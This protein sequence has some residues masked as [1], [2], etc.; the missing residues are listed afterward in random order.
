[1][2]PTKKPVPAKA[3][4]KAAGFVNWSVFDPDTGEEVLRS[5]TGFRI[6]LNEHCTIQEKALLDIA[7]ANDGNATLVAELRVIVAQDRPDVI[8]IAGIKVKQK[9][10]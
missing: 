10:A 5:R 3:K 4:Q 1:M 6:F 2:A 8:D 7:K 9:A